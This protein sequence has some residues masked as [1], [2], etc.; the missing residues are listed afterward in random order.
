MPDIAHKLLSCGAGVML[1]F[2]TSGRMV[3]A[4]E[5]PDE[6]GY[7]MRFFMAIIAGVLGLAALA[8]DMFVEADE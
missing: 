7:G 6:I 3:M 2:G 4:P 1:L 5:M 8:M